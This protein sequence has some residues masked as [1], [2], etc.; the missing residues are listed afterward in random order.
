ME[1][2][3]SP[4]VQDAE[5]WNGGVIITFDDGKSAV[6]SPSLLRAVFDQAQKLP[7]D[8]LDIAE[9]LP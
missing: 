2:Q 5:R 6:Y 8:R 1:T 9:E 7:I 4:S 3:T